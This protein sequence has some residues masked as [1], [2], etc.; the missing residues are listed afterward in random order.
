M[1]DSSDVHTISFGSAQ[2]REI[3]FSISLMMKCLLEWMKWML[4]SEIPVCDH[5]IHFNSTNCCGS[6]EDT[7]SR[8]TFVYFA[9][10]IG[11]HA[12]KIEVGDVIHM[13]QS[14]NTPPTIMQCTLRSCWLGVASAVAKERIKTRYSIRRL[15]ASQ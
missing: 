11:S 12:V 5:P 8:A 15:R 1:K 7:K 4:A 3:I 2:R 6:N 10:G 14:T 9:L 13:I